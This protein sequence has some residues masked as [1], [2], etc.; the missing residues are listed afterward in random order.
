MKPANQSWKPFNFSLRFLAGRQY[1]K[2][3]L[4]SR[5]CHLQLQL[6]TFVCLF[7]INLERKKWLQNLT[8][9]KFTMQELNILTIYTYSC[10]VDSGKTERNVNYLF[11][12]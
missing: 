1:F 5:R 10:Y 7:F 11:C 3:C 8:N 2:H 4:I 6:Q 12:T 9:E